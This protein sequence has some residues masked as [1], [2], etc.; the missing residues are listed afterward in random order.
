M[1]SQTFFPHTIVELRGLPLKLAQNIENSRSAHSYL[2]I[3]TRKYIIRSVI[4]M[5]IVCGALDSNGTDT[6]SLQSS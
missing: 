1:L 6:V 3:C 2:I 5:S 4:Q